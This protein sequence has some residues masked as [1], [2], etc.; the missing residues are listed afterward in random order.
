MTTLTG[1]RVVVTRATHQA[2]EMGQMLR[3]VG[4]EPIYYPCIEI[5][6]P[7]D[8]THLD[9]AL[10]DASQGGYDWLVLTSTNTV[11]I[12]EGVLR[13]INLTLP[14]TLRIACV[15]TATAAAAEARLGCKIDLIPEQHIA[16]ALAAALQPQQG[17]R[18]LLT[19]SDIAR[20]I[21]AQSLIA[22]GAAVKAVPAYRTVIGKGGAD[23]PALL[24]RHEIDVL[25]FT[26]ASTVRNFAVRLIEEGGKLADCDGVPTVCIGPVTA[27]TLREIGLSVDVMPTQHTLDGLIHELIEFYVQRNS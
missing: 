16:E 14:N 10:R 17:M 4:A 25:T 27:E 20:P 6:P 2:E 22:S 23:V 24:I 8:T 12:L 1:K 13:E 19:Q 11:M 7:E 9:A 5:A 21:L 3:E 26:S 15:G 18:V